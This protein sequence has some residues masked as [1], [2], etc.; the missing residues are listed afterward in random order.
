MDLRR[1][2]ATPVCARMGLAAGSNMMAQGMQRVAAITAR[3][4]TAQVEQQKSAVMAEFAD[5][6]AALPAAPERLVTRSIPTLAIP[7]LST[8]MVARMST[9]LYPFYLPADIRHCGNATPELVCLFL[10]LAW[11]RMHGRTKRPDGT[12]GPAPNSLRNAVSSLS[13]AFVQRGRRAAWDPDFPARS[14]P[15][16]SELLESFKTGYRKL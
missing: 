1:P 6:L 2:A 13:T 14:N 4:T 12:L 10:E 15:C 9:H 8:L 11:S 16:D 7:C 3:S 5:W